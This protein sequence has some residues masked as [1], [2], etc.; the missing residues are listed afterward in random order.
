LT[1]FWLYAS[2]MAPA[3]AAEALK[4]AAEALERDW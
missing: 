3:E 1:A 2:D 4:E